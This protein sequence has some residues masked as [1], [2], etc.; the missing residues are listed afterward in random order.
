M[1]HLPAHH[2]S[3]PENPCIS[4]LSSGLA[5]GHEAYGPSK[6]SPPLPLCIL[7][8]VQSS[9][10]NVFDQIALSTR[11][12]DHHGIPTHRL[13]FSSVPTH[14]SISSRPT[15][16]LIYR[17][18]QSSDRPY[19]V[20]LLYF[21]ACYSPADFNFPGSWEARL[22]LERAAAIKCPSILT[23]LAGS[24]KIQQILAAPATTHLTRFSRPNSQNIDRMRRTF[25]EIYPLDD[26]PA[27][28]RA[29][30][31]AT[32]PA[33][34]TRYV[35]K[36]QRE[37]GGNNIYGAKIPPF[38]KSLGD[39]RRKWRAY[40]LMELIQPPAAKN[41]IFRNGVVKSGEVIGEL[42]VYGVCLWRSPK[43]TEPD[44]FYRDVDIEEDERSIEILSNYAAGWLLRTKGRE[45]E[46]GGVAAGFG[47]IDSI[48][49]VK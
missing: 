25:A 40:I 12:I 46:E 30:A 11:L 17:P 14:T 26:S 27:G 8:V 29:I 49:M 6:S 32:D 10:N 23:Q 1:P 48:Y 5:E 41:S 18:P 47:A 21:R 45:S 44:P 20:S 15:R 35:L 24:K 7:F 36:P 4:L 3:V 43:G 19:E 28:Q 16:P 33:S 42:G 37:G 13:P 39:D 9:E 22:Q 31:L 38:L 34:A 2:S